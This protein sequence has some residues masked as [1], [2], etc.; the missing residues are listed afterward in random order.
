MSDLDKS[1][2]ENTSE[3]KLDIF[4]QSWGTAIRNELGLWSSNDELLESLGFPA[5]FHPDSAS[6]VIIEAV[7]RRLKEGQ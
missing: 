4:H 2:V 1:L 7:W 3:D 6:Q 5:A